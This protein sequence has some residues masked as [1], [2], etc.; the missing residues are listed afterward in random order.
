MA[1][2]Q[3]TL[4]GASCIRKLDKPILTGKDIPYNAQFIFNAGVAKINGKYVMIFRND[5]N[6]EEKYYPNGYGSNRGIY[7]C[8]TATIL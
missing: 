5:Y 3:P 1:Q 2:W 8:W 6:M 7:S 4:K